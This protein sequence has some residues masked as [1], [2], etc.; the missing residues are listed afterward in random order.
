MGG[1]SVEFESVGRPVKALYT[2][3]GG[4]KGEIK[5]EYLVDASGRAGILS[6]KSVLYHLALN[7]SANEE[8]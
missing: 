5:F 1:L 2:T 3:S 6:T 4:V 7:C 8:Y